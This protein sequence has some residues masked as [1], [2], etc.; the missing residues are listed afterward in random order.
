MVEQEQMRLLKLAREYCAM[1][2]S[3]QEADTQ[4]LEHMAQLLPK[5]HAEV[6]S[7]KKHE[8]F[9]ENAF[10]PDLDASF[11]LYTRMKHALG[12]WDKYWSDCDMQ[13]GDQAL[14]G[15]LADD[16][17]DIYA[18]LKQGL[19]FLEQHPDDMDDAISTWAS[20]YHLHWGQHLVD[21]ERHLYQL[22]S[23]SRW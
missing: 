12:Q 14:T 5:V 1:V 13:S 21:A 9:S 22:R 10:L 23:A 18:E 19:R 16:L 2:E 7:L 8:M 6:A 3:M 17:T 4:W 11:E 15:S 20:G